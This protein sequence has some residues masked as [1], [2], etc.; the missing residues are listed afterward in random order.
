M[1]RPTR[2]RLSRRLLLGFALLAAVPILLLHAWISGIVDRR[3]IA[4]EQAAT[5]LL[6]VGADEQSPAESAS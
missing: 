5:A 1:K 3:Q 4:M 2:W 6:S